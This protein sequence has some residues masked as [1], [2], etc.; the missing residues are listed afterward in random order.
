MNEYLYD[1]IETGMEESFTVSV[2]EEMEDSFRNITGD[3]NPL[4]RDDDYARQ[5]GNGK[6][7]KH[8]VFGMLTASLY[9]TVAGVY[10]PGKYSLIHSMDIKF[11]KP[12]YAGDVLTVTA[13]VVDKQDGLNLIELKVK[14]INQGKECVS[15][16]TMKVLVLK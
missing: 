10:M 8:V 16:A 4:H 11:Q 6:F 5:I 2:T 1:Q 14:I 12:V 13:V 7:K 3:I 9:S 15:K